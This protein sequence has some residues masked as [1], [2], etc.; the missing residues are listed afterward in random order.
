[1]K[2]HTSLWLWPPSQQSS[3]SSSMKTLSWSH[4]KLSQLT[5]HILWLLENFLVAPHTRIYTLKYYT[6]MPLT[7]L[8]FLSFFFTARIAFRV[9]ASDIKNFFIILFNLAFI[10]EKKKMKPYFSLSTKCSYANLSE[11]DETTFGDQSGRKPDERACGLYYNLPRRRTVFFT[12]MPQ[13]G[14]LKSR[15][16][17]AYRCKI[18]WCKSQFFFLLFFIKNNTNSTV[19]ARVLGTQVTWYNGGGSV[20]RWHNIP[21]QQAAP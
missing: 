14:P 18:Y 15:A 2:R 4:C 11:T 17:N 13:L 8:I 7:F 1:M 6:T 5:L 20:M 10:H 16:H 9:L 21:R 3:S 19:C 12:F